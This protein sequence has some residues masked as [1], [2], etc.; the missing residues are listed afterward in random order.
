MVSS[1]CYQPGIHSQSSRLCLFGMGKE[2]T[3]MLDQL[4]DKEA[5]AFLEIQS[6]IRK[7]TPSSHYGKQLL[8][9]PRVFLRGDEQALKAHYERLKQLETLWQA[10]DK[11]RVKRCLSELKNISHSV[12]KIEKQALPTVVDCFEIK[13]FLFFFRRLLGLLEE[14]Q[15]MRALYGFSFQ[16]EIWSILDPRHTQQFFFS[17]DSDYAVELRKELEK[18]RELEKAEM[19]KVCTRLERLYDLSLK[20]RTEF[21]LER[22]DIRNHAL[23]KSENCVVISENP[24]SIHY[25]FKVSEAD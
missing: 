11:D 1:F 21:L 15:G 10:T 22:S 20:N 6:L 24:F 3:L 23:R 17:I 7:I 2:T 12:E 25:Q 5:M 18:Y 14:V 4:M 8:K 19:R 13:K 16:Q 9:H